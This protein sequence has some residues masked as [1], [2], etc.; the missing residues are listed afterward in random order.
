MNNLQIEHNGKTWTAEW[1]NDMWHVGAG[2]MILSIAP[3]GDRYPITEAK[4]KHVPDH[5][6]VTEAFS[7]FDAVR[8]KMIS[9]ALERRAAPPRS[10]LRA[11]LHNLTR[12]AEDAA[13]ALESLGDP[14]DAGMLRG[15][16]RDAKTTLD[17]IE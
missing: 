2:W 8:H 16:I 12:E 10:R 6:D 17:R 3:N 11:A 1:I 14:G 7:V 5:L 13:G 9:A 15:E 4:F